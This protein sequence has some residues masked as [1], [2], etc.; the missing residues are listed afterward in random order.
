MKAIRLAIVFIGWCRP[1]CLGLVA[2]AHGP[3]DAL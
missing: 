2:G 3:A 1:V